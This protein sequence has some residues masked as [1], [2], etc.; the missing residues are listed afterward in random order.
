M[1]FKAERLSNTRM[2]RRRLKRKQRQER[3]STE[4]MRKIRLLICLVILFVLLIVPMVFLNNLF[5]YLPAIMLALLLAYSKIYVLLL[6]RMLVFE[7]QSSIANCVRGTDSRFAVNIRNK[8]ILVYPRLEIYFTMS[9]LFGGEDSVSSSVITLGPLERRAFQFDL[10]LAHI[11]TYEAGLKKVIIHDLLGIFRAELENEN[12]YQIRVAPRIFDAAKIRVSNSTFTESK[13][14]LIPTSMDGMDYTG[15]REYVMGDPIKTI[16]WKLSALTNEY[17][18]RQY[19]S[20][21]NTGIS[22]LMDFLSPL[23]DTESMMSIFDGIVETALSVEQYAKRN[24]IEAD[25]LYYNRQMAKKQYMSRANR[26]YF[27]LISDLP[28][29]T[30]EKGKMDA[31]NLLREESRATYGHGNIAFV[32]ARVTPELARTLTEIKVRRR[33]PLLFVIVPS[34]LTGNERRK[35]LK[36]L[37]ALDFARIP[38]YVL[39]TAEELTGGV[40]RNV[41]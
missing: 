12:T 22:I 9:D 27:S 18:A 10:E 3:R 40:E 41:S 15:V 8:S 2:D 34:I 35:Y 6:K 23:Y 4:A 32:T 5:G 39:E 14:M 26:D 20:Y 13:Q 16:H 36:P 1:E 25:I 30:A 37:R 24:G 38:Y 29:V 17:V 19:E 33:N 31:M 21:G 7:E 11:G 28:K